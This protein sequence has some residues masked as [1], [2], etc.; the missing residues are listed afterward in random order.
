ME[1]IAEQVFL[2]QLTSNLWKW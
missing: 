1:V 2:V